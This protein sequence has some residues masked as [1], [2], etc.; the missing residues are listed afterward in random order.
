MRNRTTWG[1]LAFPLT[2]VF[3]MGGV[4]C[5]APSV[6]ALAGNLKKGIGKNN[7]KVVQAALEGLL[8]EGGAKAVNELLSLIPKMGGAS[9]VYYWQ[10]VNTAGGF[11]DV[12][13][14]ST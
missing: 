5:A 7:D 6:K 8:A 4:A 2:L 9:D 14:R 3:V 11:H 10:L 1:R 13:A 12:F